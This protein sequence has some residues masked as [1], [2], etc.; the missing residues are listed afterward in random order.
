MEYQTRAMLKLIGKVGLISISMYGAGFYF[1]QYK[2]RE[3]EEK[4]HKIEEVRI[5]DS[6]YT[7]KIDSFNNIYRHKID[8]LDNIYQYKIDSLNSNYQ[9]KLCQLK[10][11]LVKK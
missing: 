3:E 8:S 10:R 5:I 11:E 7:H 1:Y 4:F 6:T 2:P 9:L